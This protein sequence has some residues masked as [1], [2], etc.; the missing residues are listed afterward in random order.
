MAKKK[1]DIEIIG[2]VDVNGNAS[3]TFQDVEPVKQTSK[4]NNIIGYVDINGKSSDTM[5]EDQQI[6]SVQNT[7]DGLNKVSETIKQNKKIETKKKE[8][9]KEASIIDVAKDLKNKSDY[10]STSGLSGITN[11]LT[12]MVDAPLQ[13]I[14]EGAERSKKIKAQSKEVQELDETLKTLSKISPGV[15]RAETVENVNA[16]MNDKKKSK[17]QKGIDIGL[18]VLPNILGSSHVINILKDTGESLET[19]GKGDAPKNIRK[20]IETPSNKLNEI[21]QQQGENYGT[22]TRGAGELAQVV[23][24]MVPSMTATAL[25]GDPT[26]GLTAMG[27]GAKGQATTEAEQKG[28]TLSEANAIGYAKGATEMGT[29]AL[30]GGLNFFGKGALDDIAEK[31][32]NKFIPKNKVLNFV[33]KKGA[34]IGG[35]ILEETISDVVGLAID[36]STVDPDATYTPKD[37]AK[38]AL[39]TA[40]STGILNSISGGYGKNA[41]ELNAQELEQIAQNKQVQ[42]RVNAEMNT[43]DTSKMS[44][45]QIET[46]RKQI[47]AKVLNEIQNNVNEIIQ[48]EVNAVSNE[49]SSYVDIN[50]TN[51]NNVLQENNQILNEDQID[52]ITPLNE[53]INENQNIPL[54]QQLENQATNVVENSIFEEDAMIENFRQYLED[55]NIT[56]P[57]QQDIDN[58]IVDM[59][60]YDNELSNE[61]TLEL[62][63]KYDEV[64]KQ[65]LEEQNK[66]NIPEVENQE[67]QQ[68]QPQVVNET[69]PKNTINQNISQEIINQRQ[70]QELKQELAENKADRTIPTQQIIHEDRAID[71]LANSVKALNLDNYDKFTQKEGNYVYKQSDNPKIDA[72]RRQAA[73]Y[74]RNSGQSQNFVRTIEKIISDKGIEVRFNPKLGNNVNGTYKNGVITLNPN[75]NRAGEFLAIHELTHAI[76]TKDMIDMIQKYRESNAEFNEAVEKLLKT[77]KSTEIN[78]EALADIAGQ[79][80]GNQEYINNLSMENPSLFKKI[81][82]EIKYLWH[83]FTGYKSKNQFIEDL[84]NKWETAYR[85]SEIQQNDIRYR[86]NENL[87]NK[88]KNKFNGY[89]QKEINNIESVNIKIANNENDIIKYADDIINKKNT[90][91]KMYVG[92]IKS[93]IANYISD[94]FGINVSNYNISLNKS[95]IEHSMN[96]HGT[97]TEILR[98]QVPITKEDFKNI[99]TIINAADNITKGYDTKQGKPTIT[100]EKN[101]DGNNVVTTYVSDKHHNLELQTMYKFKNK[102]TNSFTGVNESNDSLTSTPKANSD[103]NL[104]DNN[105]SQTNKNVKLEQR[106]SGDTLL[107]TQDLIDEIKSVG[108]KVDDN[109]YVTLYHQTSNE[110]AQKILETG[111]MSGK[112]NGI[113]FSTSENASQA[114]GRGQTKLEFKVPAEKLILDDLFSDNAD[115]KINSKP[116]EQIDVSEYLTDNTKFSKQE[117]T[118]KEKQNDII[119]KANPRDESLGEHTWINSADDIKTYQEALEYDDY[120]GGE[121]TP[122]F[123]EDMLNKALETGKMTVYSSYPIEQGTF[124]TPSQMEAESYA[125]SG[126]VYSKEINLTDVA[127]ID[128]LQGQ[129]AKVDGKYSKDNSTWREYL[130]KEFPNQ[131]TRTNLQDIN[132]RNKPKQENTTIQEEKPQEM[133]KNE[134]KQEKNFLTSK[135]QNELEGLKAVEETGLELTPEEQTRMKELEQKSKGI[136]KKYPDL[137][138]NN[139]YEDIKSIYGKYRDSQI[140]TENNRVLKDAK[141]FIKANNQGRRTIQEWKQIAEYIGNNAKINTSQDLQKLAMETW[142]E[143]KPNNASNLNR[144]GKKYVPFAVQDWVNSVYKGA[145]VGTEVKLSLE[146]GTDSKGNKIDL[147]PTKKGTYER[148]NT[149]KTKEV[150]P[151]IDFENKTVKIG[152]KNVS[153]FYSNITEKSKFIDLEN[154]IDLMDNDNLHYYDAISNK[155]TLKSAMK[156][157]DSNT[158]QSIGEFFTKEKFTS[159][160]VATGWILVKRYQDAGNF[161][162]MSK[163]LEKMR[164]QGTQAGQTVQMYGILQRLTPEGMEYYAQ[165]QLD[166]AYNEFSK[167]KSKKQ[168]EKYANDFTLTAE[169]HQFIKDQMEK[170]QN[171]TDEEAKK[172]EIAKVV[173]MLS[174]KMPPSKGSRIKAIMRM[175][176]LGNPKTQ[177][178]NVVGNAI[179]QPVNWASDVFAAVA[180]KAIAKKTGVR[181]KGLTQFDVLAKG[182]LQGLK[183]SIRDA[184]TGVDTRDI[185]LNRFEDSISAKP[186]YEHHTGKGAKALNTLAKTLNKANQALTNVMS[187]GD[188]IFYQSVFNNSLEN[189]MKLNKVEKP[190][191]EMIEIAKQ[192]G[193]SRTWND[194]NA[195]T[196]AVIGIRRYMNKLN[197]KGYGLGDVLV[198]F[199]KTPA[200][201]TKAIVDYSPA[202]LA[203]SIFQDGKNLKNSLENGQYSPQLQQKFTDSLGK[204]V[205]GTILWTLA[206]AAAQAGMVTGASDDDKDV[207]NFMRNTLGI[208]PYSIK[209]GNKSFTYDWAQPIAAPFAAMADAKKLSETE[210]QELASTIKAMAN[211]SFSVLMEQSF[212]RSI[213]EVFNS[214]DGPVDA[215]MKQIEG[216]PARAVPTFFKQVADL[217]DPVSRQTYV[218]GS[219]KDKIINQAQV[220]I[221]GASKGLAANRD[222]LGREIKK[223]GGDDNKLQYAFNVFLNPANTNKG[224]VSEAGKEIYEVYKATKDKGVMPR[225]A[226]Y[227]ENIGGETRNLTAE[228]RN[229]LQK[230]SG[231]MVEKN[232]K[233]LSKNSTYNSMSDEDKAE[234]IKGIV[235]YSFAKAKSEEFDVPLANIYSAADKA[236][237]NGTP[238]YDYY[239]EKNMNNEIKRKIEDKTSTYMEE[240]KKSTDYKNLT[241]SEKDQVERKVQYYTKSVTNSEELNKPISRTY[242]A[243]YNAEQN[244]MAIYDYY[245]SQIK[246]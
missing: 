83:Q 245:I 51:I 61:E 191:Q 39:M 46:T 165:K 156:N 100:F 166:N 173:K 145:G 8:E 86:K 210:Q 9:Q 47:E 181:T 89:T 125:G 244:G 217:I 149:P 45:K 162:A 117:D 88:I 229:R 163:V 238:L 63:K 103:T 98:G 6:R 12:G 180:D 49:N 93:K 105:L 26:L 134:V 73:T 107:D 14:Q 226:N 230:A 232:V 224:K 142:F 218:K 196:D 68:L 75:S 78:E 5:P 128:S 155:E 115:V 172:V 85:N 200:N 116:G 199:A 36:K 237:N 120:E 194:S 221:P 243:A 174:D 183:E 176:M 201:L 108:A 150:M 110:N 119:Q 147:K 38:T 164:E 25:T 246:K 219:E 69:K 177:V 33:T 204:G 195:Y 70:N 213:S 160:D 141:E 154:R 19:L 122:D 114:E 152:D 138:T 159:E 118:L 79:L 211:S 187:G 95:G 18:Q 77:Y 30:T 34:G 31:G 40:L 241:R 23:G 143:S 13:Y 50:R 151:K 27:I 139:K 11:A 22:I 161:E 233:Q 188:R 127:W 109:G 178:R 44:D 236:V 112:E 222:T 82:N 53:F 225:Q 81:Y 24:N 65:Y 234:V 71:S 102:K 136:T 42:Q 192:E 171:L 62:E 4:K 15:M 32:I 113:F 202:G 97:K 20:V 220:K 106:V 131:G 72:F 153:N 1:K 67:T 214:Y 55:H 87:L 169:E 158:E 197:V 80:F 64:I 124:V 207:S 170:V 74:L 43:I 28:A 206:Y 223:Y 132:E 121:L 17:F 10:V 208:Q 184:K 193:L 52:E 54:E 60:S 203:R 135:E 129:Y 186:F 205:A 91:K 190:T 101:I 58:S 179:I 242:K 168:I 130:E 182:S 76:G 104:F 126:K 239:I 198:P 16:I 41:Y 92:K 228:E 140:S 189:Q 235:N 231:K 175:S 3:D 56:N 144:Q 35:E 66:L 185:D 37:W 2:Y 157:L 57:T 84:K 227:S 209:I 59:I 99:P 96:Y 94:K 212:L 215:I 111:K 148:V 216:L 21:V 167:N 7:V 133:P 137:K 90:P 48:N 146:E 123:T 29:E 240:M